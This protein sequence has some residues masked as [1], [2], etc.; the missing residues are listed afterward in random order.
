MTPGF[1]EKLL[2]KLDRVSPEEVQGFLLRLVQEKG[3]FEQV[4]QAL[5]EGIIICDPHGTISFINRAAAKFFGAD[6]SLAAGKAVTDLIRGL[7][8]DELAASKQGAHSRDLEVFYPE[9]RYLN[10]YLAPIRPDD[11]TGELLGHAVIL[12]DITQT[13]EMTEQMIESERLG[14][15]TMMAAGVA[16]E[17][18]NPLNSLTIHLQL[19]ERKLKKAHPQ[20]HKAVEEQL[21]VA[22]GE[23]RRLHFIIE[24]FLGAM[25]PSKP[26]FEMASLNTIVQEAVAFMASEI[27]NRD[28]QTRVQLDADIPF[29]KLDPNQLKQACYNLIKNACQAMGSGGRLAIR[30]SLDDYEVRLIFSDTGQGMSPETVG[31]LFEPFFTTKQTGTGLG[32]MIVRRII[33]DHGGDLGV[34]SKE[35]L[36]STITIYLPRGAKNARWLGEPEAVESVIDV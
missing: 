17:L 7:D 16:H 18:G 29:L 2:T 4:F 3:F 6:A 35:G 8:W 5:E 30:T 25:R 33:R 19:L 11:T 24:Q 14:A 13:R 32:M 26:N 22:R 31:Q 10:F 28:I 21:E 15:L 23:L 36:G 34:E 9:R 12:R 27:Q 1:L 20:A